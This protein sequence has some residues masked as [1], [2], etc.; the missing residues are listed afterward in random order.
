[1]NQEDLPKKKELP[2]SESPVQLNKIE[3]NY[4][5]KTEEKVPVRSIINPVTGKL[6]V[7][8]LNK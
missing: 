8:P 4:K 6:G 5:P 3:P 7:L 1:L 2:F